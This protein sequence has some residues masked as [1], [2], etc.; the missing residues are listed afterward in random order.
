MSSPHPPE[1]PAVLLPGELLTLAGDHECQEMGHYRHLAFRFLPF[2]RGISRLMATLGIEC[3]RRLAEILRVVCELDP[4]TS[5]V[6][7]PAGAAWPAGTQGGPAT[8][9]IARRGQ[10][11]ATLKR[12]EARA[13]HAVRV[14]NHLHEINATPFLQ[15][16]LL[17]M[18]AQKQAERHILAELVAA[19]DGEDAEDARLA[20]SAWPRGW[21]AGARRLPGQP[22]G[23]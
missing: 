6:T 16:L 11:L 17:G 14:A 3:E 23:G 22:S 10:A 8:S 20:S 1:L 5:P 18:L 9:L 15:P 21:L 4:P 2:G 12:A 19:Y 13:E 7:S